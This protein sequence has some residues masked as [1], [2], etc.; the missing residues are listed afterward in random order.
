MDRKLAEQKQKQLRISLPQIVREEYEMILLAG[1]F[2]SSFGNKLVFRGGTALR[3]A[4]G[5]PRFSDDLDFTQ[6]Q[7][8]EEEEFQKWCQTTAEANSNLELIEALKKYY[9]LYA[10]FRVTDSVL[11]QPIGIKIEISTR[12]EKWEKG[13]DYQLKNLRSQVTP[14]TVLAQVIDLKR[15]L[16]EK[17]SISPPRVRDIFDIWFINQSLG[18]RVSMDFKGFKTTEVKRELHRLLPEGEW[19]LI[20]KWL[21]KE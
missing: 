6:L 8:I 9:T 10:K 13:K 5:S 18:Q 11:S 4:Y 16:K 7:K 19:Q 21:T 14:V 12:K 1:I 2:E 20:K 15:L 3:M 17:Q